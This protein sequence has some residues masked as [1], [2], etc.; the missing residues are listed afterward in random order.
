MAR[1]WFCVGRVKGPLE[2]MGANYGDYDTSPDQLRPGVQLSGPTLRPRQRPRQRPGP[3]PRP[4]PR[5]RLRQRQRQRPRQRP[6]Q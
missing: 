2:I 6:R 3:R 5:P 1:F 4:R